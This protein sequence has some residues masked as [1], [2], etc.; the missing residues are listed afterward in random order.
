LYNLGERKW[1]T[2]SGM[3]GQNTWKKPC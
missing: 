2:H 3:H 1:V